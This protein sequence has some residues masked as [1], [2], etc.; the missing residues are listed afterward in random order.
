M[1]RALLFIA[2][3]WS[4]N[5]VLGQTYTGNFYS[6]S[7]QG[8]YTDQ[9][10]NL[11]P[12]S[13]ASASNFWNIYHQD[14]SAIFSVWYA[15]PQPYIHVGASRPTNFFVNGNV[16]IGTTSPT[17]KL[18]I[19][20]AG[21]GP[22][23]NVALKIWA[24]NNADIFGNSQIQFSYGGGTGGYTHA[25]KSRHN[26]GALTGNAIDFY[27]WQPG[28][29]VNGEGSLSTMTLNGGNVG[30]GTTSPAYKLDVNGVINAS[31]IL[32]N[33]APFAGGGSQWTTSGPNVYYNTTG[34]VGIGT[35]TPYSKLHVDGGHIY[36]GPLAGTNSG[37]GRLSVSG[38][39]A[40]ISFSNRATSSFVES[41]SLGERWVIYNEGTATDGKLRFWSGEDKAVITKE[42]N[43]GIGT[44]SPDAKLAVKGQVHAQ[45]VKV[46]LNGAVA[47]D[48][49]FDKDYKLCS[50]EEIK[51]YIDQNKHL[52]GV[53]SAKEMEKNGVQLGEMN[54]LLLK[55][56]EE[57]TLYVIEKDKEIK[58]LKMDMER[59]KNKIR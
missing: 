39:T 3:F 30:I 31:S 12:Q 13:G 11:K 33:G 57:L 25:I 24:G 7:T 52:P 44:T 48:Y 8:M 59:M 35:T 28:D 2:S 43:V 17:A 54:M 55:K 49:V 9:W 22:G 1:K 6:P 19:N 40:E 5:F 41:P 10:L 51:N 37:V 32:I 29:P 15:S 46:D 21:D 56:I 16:G 27:L 45:E 58:A 23:Q 47:P 18:E 53:P 42:G 26:S 38:I 20:Q 36:L 34:N 50:L 4:T 14:G